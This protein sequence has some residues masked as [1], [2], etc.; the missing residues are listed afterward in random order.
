MILRETFY[1][2]RVFNS[3]IKGLE[4]KPGRRDQNIQT[5][6]AEVI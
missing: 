5:K 1:F 2:E 6:T 4:H 3:P